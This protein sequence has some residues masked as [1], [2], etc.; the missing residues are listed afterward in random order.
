MRIKVKEYK[1]TTK[2]FQCM[3]RINCHSRNLFDF[4]EDEKGSKY[5]FI[6][7][8][9][10]RNKQTNYKLSLENMYDRRFNNLPC[11]ILQI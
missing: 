7:I 8:K 9:F 5:D 10:A 11:N 2:R 6:N 3:Y 4:Y 1:R